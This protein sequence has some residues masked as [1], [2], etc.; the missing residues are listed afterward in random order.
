MLIDFN[1]TMRRMLINIK[2]G[3]TSEAD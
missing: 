2:L 1:K 3:A